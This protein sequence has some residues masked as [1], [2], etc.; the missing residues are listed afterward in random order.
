LGRSKGTV[1]VV[2]DDPSSASA[3][4]TILTRLGWQ[5]MEATS[6]AM[7]LG[8]LGKAIDVVVLDLM[9]PDGDGAAVLARVK[10]TNSRCRVAVTTGVSDPERLK[11]LRAIGPDLVL[12]KPIDLPALVRFL[13]APQDN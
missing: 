8:S 13:E 5:V 2:E 12:M 1:L 9:L 6:V 7:A 4:R 11:K 10:G 3:L